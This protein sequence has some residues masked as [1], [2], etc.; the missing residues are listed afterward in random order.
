LAGV[1]HAQ[2]SVELDLVNANYFNP[3]IADNGV[4]AGPYTASVVGQNG[5]LGGQFAIICD[6]YDTDVSTGL[7]WI[8]E[9][10]TLNEEFNG[11]ANPS[12]KL[13]NGVSTE[14]KTIDP[15]VTTEQAYEAAAWMAEQIM[16]IGD[17]NPSS[18]TTAEQ[19]SIANYNWA[20]WALFS[21][22]AVMNNSPPGGFNAQAEGDLAT[23]LSSSNINSYTLSEFN[24]VTFWIPY[25]TVGG[26]CMPSSEGSGCPD[27]NASQEY[28]TV[29]PTPEPESIVLF[30]T[31]LVSIFMLACKTERGTGE[32]PLV[33]GI[34][35][36]VR[37]IPGSGFEPIR[38]L[39]MKAYAHL[40]AGYTR[41]WH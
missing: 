8:A 18:L 27:Y 37:R 4:Y 20:I 32:Q 10:V 31:G 29:D 14:A 28:M 19:T 9:G 39:R 34:N 41:L 25:D 40:V 11:G 1:V 5:S 26:P 6:N 38:Q 23:A 12:L 3:A 17:Q 24:N 30:C 33:W 13:E 15:T 7:K 2:T 21:G 35:D 22:N 36:E 16:A